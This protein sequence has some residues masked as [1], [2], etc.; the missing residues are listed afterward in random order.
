MIFDMRLFPFNALN[1][2]HHFFPLGGF[3]SSS[4]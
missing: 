4:P 2:M 3:G 1:V